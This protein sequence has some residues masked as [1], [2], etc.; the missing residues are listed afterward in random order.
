MSA[1]KCCRHV[2]LF[3]SNLLFKNEER[4]MAVY[5]TLSPATQYG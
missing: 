1:G 3:S 5:D 2:N 4:D